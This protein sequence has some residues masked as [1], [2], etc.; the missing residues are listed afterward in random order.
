ML[1]NIEIETF[2]MNLSIFFTDIST[3]EPLESNQS[4]SEA[5]FISEDS[6]FH[7]S[8]KYQ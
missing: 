4:F 5:K 7:E 2:D 6:T 1:N 8:G 3:D